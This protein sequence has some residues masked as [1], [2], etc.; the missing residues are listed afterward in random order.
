MRQ[1]HRHTRR[2][3]T[4][5]HAFENLRFLPIQDA[6]QSVVH[7][8]NDDRPCLGDYTEFAQARPFLQLK[9]SIPRMV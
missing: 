4:N 6:E 3:Q 2:G 7:N 5:C 8:R 1:V 9:T